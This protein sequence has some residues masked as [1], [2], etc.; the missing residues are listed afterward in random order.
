MY[1]PL[2][3]IVSTTKRPFYC[4]HYLP[5]VLLSPLCT[6]TVPLSPLCTPAIV[7]AMHPCYCF[8]YAPLLLSP[9]CTPAI[10]SSMHPYCSIVSSMHPCYCLLYAPL[11]L[12]PLCTPVMPLSLLVFLLP[13]VV[14][15]WC[16]EALC[17]DC[18]SK[19]FL[20]YKTQRFPNKR[21]IKT[22]YHKE[23]C[24]G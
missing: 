1:I 18:F 5:A 15:R 12:S 8:R 4:L 6:P 19:L 7:F 3:F 21:E 17:F 24:N 23:P 16:R 2:I 11:L 20:W 9:L 10:V 22:K 14:W 13:G